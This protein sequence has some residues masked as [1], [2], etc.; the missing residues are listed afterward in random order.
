MNASLVRDV[1]FRQHQGLCVIRVLH[2]MREQVY[3]WTI[4]WPGGRQAAPSDLPRFHPSIDGVKAIAD[5][6]VHDCGHECGDGCN[7]W[8]APSRFDR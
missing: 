4:E 6:W 1:A 8:L 2:F 7:H 3:G 5:A